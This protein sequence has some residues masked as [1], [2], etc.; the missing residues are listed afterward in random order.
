MPNSDSSR[1]SP[2]ASGRPGRYAARDVLAQ[3]IDDKVFFAGEAVAG[4]FAALCR[5][6]YYSGQA[7]AE[8]VLKVLS[9]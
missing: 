3:P 6:A 2:Y 4:P 7:Q 9:G 5:G 1:R 8:A